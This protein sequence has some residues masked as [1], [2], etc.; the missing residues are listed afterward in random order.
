[1]QKSAWFIENG[2]V[3]HVSVPTDVSTV[4][5]AI[6]NESYMGF[7]YHYYF[8][9]SDYE[10]FAIAYSCFDLPK[11]NETDPDMKKQAWG[12]VVRNPL[13][14]TEEDLEQVKSLLKEKLGMGVEGG[15]M[16][17]YDLDANSISVEQGE[18][19]EYIFGITQP[20]RGGRREHK[21]K[22]EKKGKKATEIIE[23]QE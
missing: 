15:L 2:R 3:S 21:E 7:D 13:N 14:F 9:D 12:I 6:V 23:E 16:S 1:M 18:D 11:L 20:F 8:L 22:K 17:S 10:R 4:G 19:C 5:D